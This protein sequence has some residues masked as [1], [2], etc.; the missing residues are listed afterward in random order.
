MDA[1]RALSFWKDVT[2]DL[3][4][5]DRSD[6][7]AR[8]TAVLLSVYLKRPPHTLDVLCYTLSLSRSAIRE[9]L[10]VLFSKGLLYQGEV[11][12]KGGQCSIHRTVKGT[13]FLDDMADAVRSASEDLSI[14]EKRANVR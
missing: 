8:E 13:L 3:S 1:E 10:A 5:K 12:K 11:D 9:A 4:Q 2:L 7:T 6:L 14:D